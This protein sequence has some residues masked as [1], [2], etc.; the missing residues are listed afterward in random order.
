MHTGGGIQDSRL[1]AMSDVQMRQAVAFVE[2]LCEE[3]TEMQ[4]AKALE[5]W[6]L[7]CEQKGWSRPVSIEVEFPG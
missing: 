5:R 3:M 1:Y 4:I 6:E 7:I 2:T